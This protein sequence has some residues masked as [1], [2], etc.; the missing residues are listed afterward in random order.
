MA[1]EDGGTTGELPMLETGVVT[2]GGGG[3]THWV[4]MVETEV[5]V[6]VETVVRVWTD[7]VVPEITRVTGQVVR[8]V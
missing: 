7:V 5:L 4:Q 6:M 8:V 2:G 3:G 1:G